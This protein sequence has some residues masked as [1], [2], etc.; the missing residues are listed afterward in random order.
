MAR[1]TF[2]VQ[3]Q[4]LIDDDRLRPKPAGDL[5]PDWKRTIPGRVV[6]ELDQGNTVRTCPAIHDYLHLGFII[7]LWTDVFVQRVRQDA[8]GRIMPD[9]NGDKISWRTAHGAFPLEQHGADQVEGVTPLQP[10]KGVPLLIKPICPW[11][12]E[13][14][15]GWSVLILPMSFHEPEKSLPLEPIAGIVNTDHWHQ[16]H[17]P[18]RWASDAATYQMKAGTPFMHVIAFRRGEALEPAFELISEQARLAN[19]AGTLSD[20]SGGYRRQQKTFERKHDLS[21]EKHDS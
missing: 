21:G 3:S 4:Q 16:I 15:P 9:A 11:L 1:I 17:A 6:R 19:L 20:F 7:P 10:P 2:N 14:P 18:C 5:L 13:T 8:S 12:I